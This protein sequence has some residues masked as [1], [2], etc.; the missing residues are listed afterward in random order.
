MLLQSSSVFI[1]NVY[2]AWQ[3]LMNIV[4]SSLA[5]SYHA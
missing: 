3:S 1:E 5:K 4:F 2:K